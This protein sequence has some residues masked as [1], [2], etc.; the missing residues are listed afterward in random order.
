MNFRKSTLKM[1][2]NTW[3]QSREYG[4]GRDGFHVYLDAVYDVFA[5]LRKTKGKAKKAGNKVIRWRKLRRISKNSHPMYLII[6]GS[7]AE[8]KRMQSRWTQALRYA[9]KYRDDREHLTLT[10]FFKNNGGVAGCARKLGTKEQPK[11]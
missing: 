10:E 4:H 9:W 1:L 2:S 6:L 3:K 8:D 5:K 11:V 7:S